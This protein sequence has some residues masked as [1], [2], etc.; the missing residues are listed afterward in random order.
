MMEMDFIRD[1]RTHLE[2]P[3]EHQLFEASLRNYCSHGNPLRFNN[4]AFAMRELVT[5][6][7]DRKAPEQDVISAPW[8]TQKPSE[9]KV[10][11]KQQLKYCAQKHIPD[12]IISK[13]TR[14]QIEEKTNNYIKKFRIFNK[15]THVTEKYFKNE[16]KAVFDE[17][18]QLIELTS[19]AYDIFDDFENLI[20]EEVRASID[21][22]IREI[23]RE[24]IHDE[25]DALSSNTIVDN[26]KV[27]GV[28]LITMNKKFLYFLIEGEIYITRQYGKRDD[29]A[30]AC[31]H[32]PFWFAVSVS[33]QDFTK[34][35][36]LNVKVMVD[37]SAWYSNSEDDHEYQS[38]KNSAEFLWSIDYINISSREKEKLFPGVTKLYISSDTN[39][40]ATYE[41]CTIE[42]NS[43]DDLPF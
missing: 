40:E 29:F 27:T 14:E 12:N 31:D 23:T 33:S 43:H 42:D 9:K 2:T 39:S 38:L 28:R 25:I 4:F 22:E 11:R 19:K 1:F 13:N 21:S 6:I 17:V 7:L 8:Y 32:Y 10:T 16:A 30:E 24:K 18:K 20:S 36:P 26:S 37:T 41:S 3:F 15:Y 34:V 35:K 5:N